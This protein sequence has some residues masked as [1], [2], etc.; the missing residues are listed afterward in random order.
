MTAFEGI[1]LY[2]HSKITYSTL[3]ITQYVTVWPNTSAEEQV[4]MEIPDCFIRNCL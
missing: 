2:V 3:S 1:G 4:F